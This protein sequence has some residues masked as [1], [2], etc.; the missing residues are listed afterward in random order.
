MG[1]GDRQAGVGDVEVTKDKKA[2]D[3]LREAV[4]RGDKLMAERKRNARYPNG[5]PMFDQTGMMLDQ[6]GKRSIFDD[7][8][9]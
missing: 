1:R 4:K 9:E 2:E 6:D 3:I 5:A 8:D 7:V